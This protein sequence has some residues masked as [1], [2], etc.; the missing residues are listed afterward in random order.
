MAA[1]DE[2]ADVDFGSRLV[3]LRAVGAALGLTSAQMPD[4]N[5]ANSQRT[6]L[7]W[8]N[9]ARVAKSLPALPDLDYTG[10][11]PALNALIEQANIVNPPTVITAPVVS[12]TGVVGNVLSATNGTWTDV[13]TSYTR[14]WLRSGV[15][16]AG[17]TATTYTLVAADSGTNVACRVTATNSGGSSA[18]ST[19]NAIAVA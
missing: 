17:A 9:V 10:F 12:G 11:V 14:A 7:H 3:A 19:S 18:P 6:Y 1:I 5:G 15:V 4:V 8:I 16:I 2:L 13:P